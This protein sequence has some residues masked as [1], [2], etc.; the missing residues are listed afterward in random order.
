MV[1]RRKWDTTKQACKISRC[2]N[3]RIVNPEKRIAW[4][5]QEEPGLHKQLAHDQ[6]LLRGVAVPQT[7][8][9]AWK[10][11]TIQETTTFAIEGHVRSLSHQF[12]Y[13]LCLLGESLWP[14]EQMSKWDKN[15]LNLFLAKYCCTWP[16]F[17]ASANMHYA[18]ILEWCGQE[19][20]T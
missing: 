7:V 11:N 4:Y 18:P 1:P 17:I 9:P 15:V 3:W 14:D 13:C 8:F 19:T 2:D 12:L 10:C 16:D 5:V 20:L 6:R